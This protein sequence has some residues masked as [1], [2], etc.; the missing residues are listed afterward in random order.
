VGRLFATFDKQI[1]LA[2][3]VINLLGRQIQNVSW[4]VYGRSSMMPV[5]VLPYNYS[6]HVV[7]VGGLFLSRISRRDQMCIRLLM[8]RTQTYTVSKDTTRVSRT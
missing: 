4:V 2:D 5:F 3:H 8:A 7:Q 6:R 1:V